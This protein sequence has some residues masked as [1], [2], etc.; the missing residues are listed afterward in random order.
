MSYLR[1]VRFTVLGGVLLETPI[2]G[3]VETLTSAPAFDPITKTKRE[4]IIGIYTDDG[5]RIDIDGKLPN[6]NWIILPFAAHVFND[7]DFLNA[8][9]AFREYT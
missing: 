5:R 6:T 8:I 7:D 9:E 2:Y 3:Y 1:K 4:I